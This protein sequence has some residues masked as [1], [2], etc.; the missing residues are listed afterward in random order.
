MTSR[1]LM[2][3]DEEDLVWTTSRQMQRARPDL[4]FVGL[5]DPREALRHVRQQ[6]PDLLI[7]D[8]RMPQMSGLELLLAAR[9]TSPDL[10]VILVTAHG[11]G[12]VRTELQR[13]RAVQYMEKPFAFQALLDAV[14]RALDRPTGF[15][16][17][18]SLPMLPDLVQMYALARMHGTLRIARGTRQG[19]LWFE[20]GEIVHATC[21]AL[22]GPQAVYELLSWE[23]GAFRMDPPSAP[24]ERSVQASWQELL[25]EGC[26]LQDEGRREGAEATPAPAGVT[27]GALGTRAGSLV[28]ALN[29]L[30]AEAP[31]AVTALLADLDGREALALRAQP[32]A[33][34][35]PEVV[36]E[37]LRDV[38]G[39]VG[40]LEC[41]GP[42]CAVGLAWDRR[43]GLALLAT[44]RLG[45]AGPAR[46]RSAFARWREAFH[47]GASGK[48]E[49]A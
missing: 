22:T 21:G 7:T 20:A 17:A 43:A 32:A 31:A 1:V 44:D 42:G 41:V 36:A 12:H 47:A 10:P 11:N 23:G 49:E 39:A 37:L 4:E 48:T 9:E 40:S 35:W 29:E 13:T 34:G 2:V 27:G 38:D 30:L 25:M 19:T 3:D 5:S 18:I 26:R 15:S 24:P 6:A 14:E 45:E 28:R 46:F 8:L 16:G 33:A